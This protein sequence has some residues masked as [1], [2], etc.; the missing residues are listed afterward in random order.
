MS[1]IDLG[2]AAPWSP[3][4]T[5]RPRRPRLS[6]PTRRA[7]ALA[8]AVLAALV[9]GDA[10]A[11]SAPVLHIGTGAQR[12]DLGGGRIFVTRYS[13]E[14]PH[15]LEVYGPAGA[16]L[17]GADLGDAQQ[18]A[19]ADAD[20]AVL[21]VWLGDGRALEN[22]RALDPRT[23]R[24]LWQRGGVSLIGR[25]GGRLLLED[26]TQSPATPDSA[27]RPPIALLAVDERTGATLWS[28][29]VPAGREAS[30]GRPIGGGWELTSLTVLGPDGV[31]TG[32]DLATGAPA[33]TERLRRPGAAAIFELGEDRGAPGARAGQVVVTAAGGD[34][35]YDRASGRP[36]WHLPP[37]GLGGLVG[38][39]PGRWCR[40][41]D[42]GFAAFDAGTGRPAW[43]VEGYDTIVGASAQPATLVLTA[44]GRQ[45]D[46]MARG[47]L[48]DAHTGAVRARLGDWRPVG[49]QGGRVVVWRRDDGQLDTRLG[50]LDPAGGRITVFGTGASWVGVPACA[51]DERLVACG[52]AGEVTV[53]PLPAAARR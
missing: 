13:G 30:L 25:F 33:R 46:P 14:G 10:S 32:Y 22:V 53:W 4:E 49:V 20:V 36:L 45:G 27:Q 12:A 28:S 52:L 16:R 31:L 39:A 1:V 38:C 8:V 40:A 42:G 29:T 35:V 6:G 50:L 37:A 24:Q 48:V 3:P 21:H 41:E 7:A 11:V 43:R 23:G 17:W 51:A 2:D 5:P 26:T 44:G 18:L 15:R 19:Y 34:D 9:P 47:V